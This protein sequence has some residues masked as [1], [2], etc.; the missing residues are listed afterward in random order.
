MSE[1]QDSKMTIVEIL[2]TIQTIEERNQNQNKTKQ[3]LINTP[4]KR[5]INY[6][7]KRTDTKQRKKIKTCRKKKITIE[8]YEMFYFVAYHTI[9]KLFLVSANRR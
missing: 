3:N 4:Y 2:V 7:Q 9:L 1:N 8:K 6:N 5:K